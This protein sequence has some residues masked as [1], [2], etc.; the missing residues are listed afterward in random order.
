MNPD[1][2]RRLTNASADFEEPGAQRFDLYRAPRFRQLQKT[3]LIDQIVGEGMQQEAEGVGQKAVTAQAVGSETVLEF[4]NAV[5]TF[6]AVVVKSEDLG[7]SARDIGDH[8]AQVGSYRGVLSLV[9]DAPLARPGAR[10]VRKAGEAALREFRATIT[11][12]Q[13]FL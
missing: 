2:A 10:A 11:V 3:K 1:A 6:T 4:F 5:L 8:E 12:L 13:F 9:A 7:S